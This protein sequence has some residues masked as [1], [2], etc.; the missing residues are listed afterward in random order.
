MVASDVDAVY[1]ADITVALEVL[2][3]AYK[4]PLGIGL[5]SGDRFGPVV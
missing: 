1:V 5:A 4:A 2:W 3:L